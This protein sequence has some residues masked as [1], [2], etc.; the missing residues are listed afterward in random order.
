MRSTNQGQTVHE[1]AIGMREMQ[2][3]KQKTRQTDQQTIKI[4][5]ERRCMYEKMLNKLCLVYQVFRQIA[6][7]LCIQIAKCNNQLFKNK[8]I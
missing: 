3:E 5:D 8:G 1:T 2:T 4:I 6:T 7:F